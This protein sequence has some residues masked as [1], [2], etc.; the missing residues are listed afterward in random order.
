MG[1]RRLW[2]TSRR[3]FRQTIFTTF[4]AALP[5]EED[6]AVL[7]LGELQK[8]TWKIWAQQ[9]LHNRRKEGLFWTIILEYLRN[10]LKICVKLHRKKTNT[11]KFISGVCELNEYIIP[12]RLMSS[13][14][15]WPVT[16]NI[17][18]SS[19]LTWPVTVNS[20]MSSN[21]TWPAT[22]NSMISNNLNWPATVNNMI[23][24][25]LT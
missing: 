20:M 15:T 17:M 10:R 14:L 25:N 16:M 3:D 22:V 19:N 5:L 1:A 18:M 21:L 12:C 24:N 8:K 2:A 13:N 7:A 11:R 9:I 4:G 23:G 6:T